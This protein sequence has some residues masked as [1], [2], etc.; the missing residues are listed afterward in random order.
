MRTAVDVS[1]SDAAHDGEEPSTF[2]G[3][4]RDLARRSPEERHRVLRHARI[5]V[6]PD[7]TDAWDETLANPIH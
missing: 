3:S 2:Q 5:A 4:L 6:E 7:V 1:D